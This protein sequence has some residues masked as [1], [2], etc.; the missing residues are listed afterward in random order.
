MRPKAVCAVEDE[1]HAAFIGRLAKCSMKAFGGTSTPPALM[2]GSAM[3]AA[4]CPLDCMSNIFSARSRLASADSS[5]LPL[6]M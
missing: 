3:I 5:A 6:S 2:M 4:P 1:Q